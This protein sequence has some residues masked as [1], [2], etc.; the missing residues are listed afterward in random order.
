VPEAWGRQNG[1]GEDLA[2]T[3]PPVQGFGL[4]VGDGATGADHLFGW[5]AGS[6]GFT[7]ADLGGDLVHVPVD[8]VTTSERSPHQQGQR[9]I[10]TRADISRSDVPL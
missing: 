9:L 1:G 3:G 8:D 2:N 4:A 5:C 6:G 7:A 10:R